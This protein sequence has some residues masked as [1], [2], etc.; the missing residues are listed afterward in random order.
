MK[1]HYLVLTLGVL[2][3]VLISFSFVS[4]FKSN[5]FANLG[6]VIA[7][8]I[9]I[10]TQT[11][12]KIADAKEI[13][14]SGQLEIVQ[15]ENLKNKKSW[16]EY[17]IKGTG[18]NRVLIT[19]DNLDSLNLVAG[20][21]ISLTGVFANNE[22]KTST[23]KIE[24]IRSDS[25]NAARLSQ[26]QLS[27]DGKRKYKVAVILFNFSD[28]SS[29]THSASDV[30]DIMY[31]NTPNLSVNN[32][33]QDVSSGTFKVVGSTDPAGDVYGWYT[34]PVTQ[35]G[36]TSNY[37]YSWRDFANQAAAADG[38]VEGNYDAV[39]YNF[40][41]GTTN[42][43]WSGVANLIPV[44][45]T[46]V[47]SVPW[48]FING[49]YTGTYAHELGHVLGLRHASSLS[50][51]DGNGGKTTISTNC[52]VT[53]YGDPF[54]TM[55]AVDGLYY[56]VRNKDYLGFLAARN[57][58]VVSTSGTYTLKSGNVPI[59]QSQNAIAAGIY[60]IKIPIGN[61]GGQGNSLYYYLESRDATK[62][63]SGISALAQSGITIRLGINDNAPIYHNNG[64]LNSQDSSS[65]SYIVDTH[66][67]T[68]TFSD[69]PLQLGETF[70]DQGRN[71][72]IT[73]LGP[74]P[75]G[76]SIKVEF[77][78]GAINCTFSTPTF[79]SSPYFQ[80]G[81]LGSTS[82]YNYQIINNDTGTNCPPRILSFRSNAY[83]LLLHTPYFSKSP[84]TLAVGAKEKGS[85]NI[86][87]PSS[88]SNTTV[89][90][91]EITASDLFSS[92]YAQNILSV[93]APSGVCTPAAPYVLAPTRGIEIQPGGSSTSSTIFINRNSADC[94][95]NIFT[96]SIENYRAGA[97]WTVS[98]LANNGVLTADPG[99]NL[100][101]DV[102]V[103]APPT[104]NPYTYVFSVKV[105]DNTNNIDY[106][107]VGNIYYVIR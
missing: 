93:P 28:N 54:D 66:S 41:T 87:I 37:R 88:Q 21:Q 10:V 45:N 85:I 16:N 84:I 1:K 61:S 107:I 40:P 3:I 15:A 94:S 79:E 57:I 46:T 62:W 53:D 25:E 72:K 80:K 7:S 106:G 59:T 92:T 35:A 68:S 58:K 103:N 29:Q 48:V 8:K 55:G 6:A 69:A 63:D 50:C 5:S 22:I 100:N 64:T 27:K 98:P 19:S 73:Y 83:P 51:V 89:E 11:P 24:V 95:N 36:C 71:L 74:V 81:F 23:K 77:L 47:G 44:P 39:F 96:V 14:L 42:C 34:L 75:G 30:K 65:K 102:E 20:S 12:S 9:K 38:F 78:R 101:I 90:L 70:Y 32:F 26:P 13:T 18:E 31:G 82:S 104:A 56:N 91:Y 60:A 105:F 43:A 76:K 52:T 33:L 17:W 2:A 99:N 4:S 97:G 86:D 67:S 49:E